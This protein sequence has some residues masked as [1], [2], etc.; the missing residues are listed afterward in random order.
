VI[1]ADGGFRK[2]KPVSLKPAVDAALAN[3][4][5]PSVT[6]TALFAFSSA[7]MHAKLPHIIAKIAKKEYP[8][9]YFLYKKIFFKSITLYILGLIIGAYMLFDINVFKIYS[10]RVVDFKSFIILSFAW[11]LQLFTYAIITFTRL[12]KRELFVSITIVSSFYTIISTILLLKY[13]S[14]KYVFL[15]LLSSYLFA[16]PYILKKSKDFLKQKGIS[17]L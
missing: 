12:F 11:L 2:D 6:M 14:V 8:T 5:C 15:G 4:A 16:L 17:L 1:T 3:G 7:I 9:A 10:Q 13:L